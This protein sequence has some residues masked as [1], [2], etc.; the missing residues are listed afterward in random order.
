M[1]GGG[2]PTKFG[3]GRSL[4]GEINLVPF[5]D[6]LS[7]CICFLLMTAIWVEV[8]AI[9]LHQLL[10]TAAPEVERPLE[11]Q[12]RLQ[13]PERL[14]V[15]LEQQGRVIQTQALEGRDFEELKSR[16][17]AWVGQLQAA[18]LARNPEAQVS[19]RLVPTAAVDYGSMVAVLDILRGYGIS[20]LAVVPVRE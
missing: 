20:A 19:A 6:L 9:P 12:V 11:L 7:M 5:I 13:T 4:D 2:G 15:S 8:G 10:G 17:S 16:V 18:I 1:A 14:S 3:R